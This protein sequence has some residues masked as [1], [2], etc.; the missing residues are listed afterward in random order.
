MN[1]IPK[2]TVKL[3]DILIGGGNRVTVQTMWKKS[4]EHFD[5]GDLSTIKELEAC[6]CD[7]LRFSVPNLKSASV[8]KEIKNSISVPLVADIH[9]D[10]KIAL[11]CISDSIDK[12]RINPGNIGDE[13]KVKEVLSA[14]SDEGIP[15]RIGI[16]SGSL[17]QR[18]SE[19]EDKAEAMIRSAEHEIDI[20]E[21]YQF[22]NAL[23]SLKS[24]NADA[25]VHANRT[26]YEK[27]SYPLHLGVTEAGPLTA[28]LVKS[29]IAL[30]GLLKDGIGDTIRVSLTDSPMQ[31]VIAGREILRAC[32]LQ[33]EG[34]EIISCPRCGRATFDTHAF[35]SSVYEDLY[36]IRKNIKVAVMG[37]LVNGPGEAADADIAITGSGK[38]L[39]IFKHGKI[40]RKIDENK[41]RK[42]FLDVIEE[43]IS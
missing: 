8:L 6:G 33:N 38:K 28:G 5:D 40:Y 29:S 16:N 41:G 9:F 24:S 13:W 3:G 7:I 17:D 25:T 10:Y 37:C 42:E 35:I 32:G 21:K 12:I 39:V 1:K 15:I 22:K 19:I 11:R 2:N 23:F 43:F 30:A 34:V 27:Y 4:L 36:K 20:L 26:F 31:E 18:F 14:A